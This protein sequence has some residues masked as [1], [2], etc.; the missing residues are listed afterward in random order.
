MTKEGYLNF[1][2]QLL[3]EHYNSIRETGSASS[4]SQQFINGYLTAARTLNAVYQKELN[5]Y[6]ERIH[7][8]VFHMTID[9]R[10]KSLNMPDVNEND[11]DIPTYK[12][13]GVKLK[14]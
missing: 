10:R 8:E 12:R 2:G 11:L 5:D 14:F 6:A 4:D 9:Q 3:R 13:K 7:F 1:L